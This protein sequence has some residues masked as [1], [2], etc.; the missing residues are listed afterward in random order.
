M[1]NRHDRS[2]TAQVGEAHI[3]DTIAHQNPNDPTGTKHMIFT[4]WN[5]NAVQDFNNEV[6][7]WKA[8][9]AALTISALAISLDASANEVAGDLKYADALIGLAN[10]V[11]INP[12]DTTSGVLVDT[13][14]TV[15]A[16]P[17]GKALYLSFDSLPDAAIKYIN[18]DITFTY[19][20]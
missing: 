8:T 12:F 19:D 1:Q 13:S 7:I 6:P 18:V 3:D 5:P 14:I 4:V 11:V 17:S 10:P 2:T 20:T 16:V 15:G 9:D